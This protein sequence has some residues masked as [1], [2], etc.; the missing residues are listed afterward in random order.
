MAWNKSSV[1][2]EIRLGQAVLGARGSSTP[3]ITGNSGHALALAFGGDGVVTHA[4]IRGDSGYALPLGFG[5]DGNIGNSTITGD[6]GYALPL[7]FGSG[8]IAHEQNITGSSGFALPLA[9]GSGSVVATIT[10]GFGFALPLRFGNTGA[11][12]STTTGFVCF[13]AGVDRTSYCSPN[14]LDVSRSLGSIKSARFQIHDS[15]A[16]FR[17]AIGSEVVWYFDGTRIFGGTIESREEFWP[18]GENR[19]LMRMS[20]DCAGY[21]AILQRR[22]VQKHYTLFMGG[23]ANITIADLVTNFLD[24]EG[25]SFS[26]GAD[27]GISLEEQTF[28]G[29]TVHEAIKQILDKANWDYEVDD[30]K[31]LRIFSSSAGKGSCPFSITDANNTDWRGMSVK[32]SRGQYRN[33]QGVKNNRDLKAL[34]T[35]SVQGDGVSRSYPTT[36][37]LNVKP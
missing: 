6:T 3:Q 30:Y 34:W 31:I 12:L 28:N 1:L 8:L 16:S 9:F 35:D 22:I 7:A 18:I 15:A 32:Q 19:Q 29:V 20:I 21:G 2:G 14:S 10:G 13:I 33:R 37:V 23:L 5:A 25:I 11:L 24:N 17:P 4:D 27:P 26:M 36:Y